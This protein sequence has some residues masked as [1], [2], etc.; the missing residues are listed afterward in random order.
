MNEQ[1]YKVYGYRWIVLL[2][3]SLIQAVMQMLWI[4]FAPITGDAAAFYNVSVLQIGFLAMSFMIVY[5]FVSIPASW[6]IDRFGI[7]IGVGLGVI[8]TA[9]FGF[10][11]GYFGDN[12]KMVM[13]AMIGLGIAQPFILNSI[14]ALCAKWFPLD[15]RATAG[16]LAVMAQF[17]GI[18]VGM[19]VT[20]FLVIKFGIP[21]MLNVYGIITVICAVLFLIFVKAAPPTPPAEVDTERTLVFDGLK[22]IFKQRDMII[23]IT[24]FF[25]GLGIFNAVTTWIEQIVAP[26]GFSIVQ[27]GT[28]G[29]ILMLGGIVGC[30]IIPVLSDKLRKRKP[31]IILCVLVCTPGLVGMTF[32]TSFWLLLVSGFFFGFFFMSVAPIAFQYS[33]E[34]SYPAPE[35]TSQ[36]L[37]MLAGQISGII[38]IF[39]MDM[40]RTASGSMTPFLIVMIGLMLINIVLSFV[41][42]ESTMITSEQ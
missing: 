19:A 24:I 5:I 26:R 12:Y 35:A 41:L 34:V 20:P 38:F 11:R 2:F 18:V 8:L 27:A 40:F 25:I 7:K 23:L 4:T 1:T 30:L 15:E 9:I 14:T 33:A 32:V 28:L 37:L 42:K 10:T 36:G 6:T 22:H 31:L 21:G 29:G 3:Y 16:G 17:A 39:A 13:I